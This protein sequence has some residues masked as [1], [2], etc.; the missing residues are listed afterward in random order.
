[1]ISCCCSVYGRVV[2]SYVLI[3]YL[4]YCIVDDARVMT[5]KTCLPPFSYLVTILREYFL[6]FLEHAFSQRE[7]ERESII[8]ISGISSLS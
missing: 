8:I 6:G 2:C 1:M 7:R 3:L 5:D 4:G